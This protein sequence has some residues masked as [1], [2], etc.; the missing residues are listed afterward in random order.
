MVERLRKNKNPLS[1]SDECNE[2]NV[3]ESEKAMRYFPED[4]QFKP[5]IFR[6][7]IKI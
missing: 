5:K 7:G 6:T 1:H 2:L 4:G 3:T